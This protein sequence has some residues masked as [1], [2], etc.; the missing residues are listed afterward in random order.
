MP[1]IHIVVFVVF[2]AFC[3]AGHLGWGMECFMLLLASIAATASPL[4]LLLII[5]Y[6][7]YAISSLIAERCTDN[8]HLRVTFGTIIP[9][10]IALSVAGVCLWL[11]SSTKTG[12]LVLCMYFVCVFSLMLMR[13]GRL[14]I[15]LFCYV[16]GI[17]LFG[18]IAIAVQQIENPPTEFQKAFAEAF[19]KAVQEKAAS[20]STNLTNQTANP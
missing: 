11:N 7:L 10:V 3:G 16:L 9:V 13:A 20:S 1:F 2:I 19:L 6:V 14:W 12:W 18:S 15:A 5:P 17:C 8:Q 4:P